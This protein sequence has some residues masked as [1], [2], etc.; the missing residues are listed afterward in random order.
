MDEVA[1]ASAGLHE[2]GT[3]GDTVGLQ[4]AH[5]K[6][7]GHS[8][9][10]FAQL[11]CALAWLAIAGV[12]LPQF[13]MVTKEFMALWSDTTAK[14]KPSPDKKRGMV[15]PIKEGELQTIVQV[16]A[17]MALVECTDAA[18]ADTWS[19]TAWV[20]VMVCALNRL[21]GKRARPEAG[22]WTLLERRAVAS[23]D[24]AV[25]RRSNFN[26]AYPTS[27]VG[28]QKDM[29]SRRVGYGGEEQ[30]ICHELTWDQVAPALP[31]RAHGG[32]VDCLLW[33]CP[34]TREFLLHPE[35][36]IKDDKD[37]ELPKLPG[38][39]HVKKGDLLKI[40]E[41]LVVRNVCDWVP[42]NKVQKVKG[43]PVLN[44]L[45]GVTK[46]AVL[47]D[48][49]PVLRLIM[50]LT[51]SNSTQHQLEGGCMGLPNITSWQSLV[52]CPGEEVK[53]HQSDMSSAFYL[54]RLPAQWK[55]Y[56]AFNVLAQGEDIGGQV[57]VCYALCC[58]VI[59]MGCLNSVG[60]MQEA[61]ENLL[62]HQGLCP[63]Q[64]IAR[65]RDIPPWLNDVLETAKSEGRS[66][67]HV[68][69]DNYAGGERV[70]QGGPGFDSQL[71]HDLAERAWAQAGVISSDKRVSGADTAVELGAEVN[72][73]SK[74]LGVSTEKLV[75]VIQSTWWM[76]CQSYLSRKHVQILAGRWVFILQFRRPGMSFLQQTWKFISSSG[77]I[78]SSLR[79]AVKAEFLALVCMAPVL[80]CNLGASISEHLICTDASEKAGSIEVA[81]ELTA[82]GRDFLGGVESKK[83]DIKDTPAELLLISL[84]N[85]IGG[86]FRAYDL[87]G[88]EPAGRI[89]VELDDAANRVTTRR[90]PGV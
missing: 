66:W 19:R 77:A 58:S 43:T 52:I 76:L 48:G 15:F 32:C 26:V 89:A 53:I 88:V 24:D 35:W 36:L 16:F 39:V 17:G 23:L 40:A 29:G 62:L 37:I 50:N 41:E 3:G 82:E 83:A 55:P 8:C 63:S 86:A 38:K 56:L 20:Y 81:H 73:S 72:G 14:T 18:I 46:H 90:W 57:G 2:S 42:L 69:L 6:Q 75:K 28:W 65:G 85:G 10:T 68:Y 1:L 74:T 4:L 71:C 12:N 22:R 25:Q 13:D 49:R 31:P 7:L 11:G 21:A 79:C 44:G 61:S 5:L 34:R 80:H 51:G 60:I 33:V 47:E 67:W 9:T 87:L 64:Q 54:F 45:F 84:F 78:T 30:S 70:R 59:P 27:E